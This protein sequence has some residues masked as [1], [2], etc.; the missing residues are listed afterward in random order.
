MSGY[1]WIA[2]PREQGSM[3]N[4]DQV[5]GRFGSQPSYFDNLKYQHVRPIICIK[6]PVFEEKYEATLESNYLGEAINGEKYGQKVNGY[7]ASDTAAQEE[8]GAW[9]L[10]YQNKAYTY[11][12]SDNTIKAG[13][14]LEELYTKEGYGD[15]TGADVSEI[16]QGLNPLTKKLGGFTVENTNSS[17]KA[18]GYLTDPDKWA[19]YKN[20]DSIFAISSPSFELFVESYNEAGKKANDGRKTI[21]AWPGYGFGYTTAGMSDFDSKFNRGIYDAQ[22]TYWL[23]SVSSVDGCMNVWP[24]EDGTKVSEYGVGKSG[25]S[26]RPI[27]CIKTPVFLEKYAGSLVDE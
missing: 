8:A 5:V 1:W 23:A 11:L 14:I 9:R 22:E 24:A 2:S 21:Y 13:V 10:F 18:L 12:I 20:E 7:T 6:T 17:I 15:K 4:V 26:F 19:K 27:V 25:N 3:L 16:G